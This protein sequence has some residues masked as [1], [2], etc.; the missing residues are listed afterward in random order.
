[1]SLFDCINRADAMISDVSGVASDFLYS[2]KPF[3]LTNMAA[4][5]RRDEFETSFPLAKAAYVLDEAPAEH[6]PA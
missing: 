2:A 3:A 1:M 5:R 4:P 6:R